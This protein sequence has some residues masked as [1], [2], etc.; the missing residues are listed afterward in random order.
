MGDQPA[1]LFALAG[2]ICPRSAQSAC[3]ERAF[4]TD[5]VV[6]PL[7]PARPSLSRTPRA[8]IFAPETLVFSKILRATNVRCAKRP[9]SIKHCKNQY[10]THF[11]ACAPR[12]KNDGK[13]F[14]E[15][16]RWCPMLQMRSDTAPG[17]SGSVC[18]A[19][20]NRF[21]TSLGRSWPTRGA[22][23][24]AFGRHLALHKPSRACP[25]ASPKRP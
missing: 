25:D 19:A 21:W 6:L 11:A 23:R 17:R 24:S 2:S 7:E 20:R 18:G 3:F 10:E 4:S 13:S 12:R 15:R 16:V 1:Q 5:L 8:S 14:R 9:T 22:S